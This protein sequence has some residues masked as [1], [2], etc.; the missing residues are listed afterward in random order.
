[1]KDKYPLIGDARGMGLMQAV[2]LVKN[3]KKKTPA[4]KEVDRILVESYK[5]GLILLPCG[6]SGIRLIPPLVIGEDELNEGLDIFEKAFR[7]VK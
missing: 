2:E 6:N 5:M 1:M 4:K 7:A 3:R